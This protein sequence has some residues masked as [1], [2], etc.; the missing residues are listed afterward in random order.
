MVFNRRNGFRIGLLVVLVLLGVY[1]YTSGKQHQLFVDNMAVEIEGKAYAPE[2]LVRAAFDGGEP[3]E[4]A[5]GDRDVTQVVGPRHTVKVE[6]LNESGD[7]VKTLEGEFRWVSTKKGMFSVP[8]FL[9]GAP[10]PMIDS[11]V[12]E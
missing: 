7:V 3:L 8:A 9:G 6:V 2:A 4:L 11:P 1:L 10:S 12:A 5:S